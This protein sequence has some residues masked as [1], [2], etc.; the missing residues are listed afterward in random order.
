MI[1]R[2]LDCKS[3]LVCRAQ[4]GSLASRTHSSRHLFFPQ[5][6]IPKYLLIP[7]GSGVGTK[8]CPFSCVSKSPSHLPG[9]RREVIQNSIFLRPAKISCLR[10]FIAKTGRKIHVYSLKEHMA[11]LTCTFVFKCWNAMFVFS[12]NLIKAYSVFWSHSTPP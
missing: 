8:D 5:A 11:L 1:P 12:E 3:A 9:Q 2:F 6:L 7:L 4:V 10:Y